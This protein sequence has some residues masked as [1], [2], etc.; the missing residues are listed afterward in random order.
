MGTRVAR[1]VQDLAERLLGS[2]AGA[3]YARIEPDV[4]QPAD[5]FLDLSGED[6]RSR[7]FVTSDAE[8]RE[9]ALRPEF[10]IPVARAWLV[11]ANWLPPR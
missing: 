3:G 8:G 2:F 6:I 10:T 5:V 11:T 7:M 9:W 4:L 1:T